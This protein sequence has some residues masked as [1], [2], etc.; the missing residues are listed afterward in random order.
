MIKNLA[1]SSAVLPSA[2]PKANCGIAQNAGTH[3]SWIDVN[4][5]LRLH[6]QGNPLLPRDSVVKV[7]TKVSSI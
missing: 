4:F 7:E 2:V 6:F 1:P 5:V 3:T